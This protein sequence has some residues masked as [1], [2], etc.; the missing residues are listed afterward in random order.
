[1]D[2]KPVPQATKGE[3]FSIQTETLVRR[4]DKVYKWI[5]RN[6]DF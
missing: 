5:E 3:T 4:G 1:V 6:E 2:L